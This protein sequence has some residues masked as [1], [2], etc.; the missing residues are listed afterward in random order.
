MQVSCA[1]IGRQ[2]GLEGRG[3]DTF[4]FEFVDEVGG[5][6]GG[7]VVVHGDGAAEGGEGETCCVADPAGGTGY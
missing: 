4:G 1:L 7:A 6:G 3:V 5:R 2:V